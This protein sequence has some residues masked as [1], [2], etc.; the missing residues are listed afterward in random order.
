M[1]LMQKEICEQP[2]AL[3]DCYSYNKTAFEKLVGEIKAKKI[4]N[5]VIA[6]RGTSDHA[7]IYGKYL[8]ESMVGVPVGLSAASAVTLY[9]GNIRSVSYT[10]LPDDS[11][12]SCY[13]RGF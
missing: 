13:C 10:H 3:R 1:T 6:A 12:V 7:G 4:S 2:Q 5:V 11:R 9:G 8:I